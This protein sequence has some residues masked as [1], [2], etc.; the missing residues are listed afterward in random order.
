MTVGFGGVDIRHWKSSCGERSYEV[1]VEERKHCCLSF[2]FFPPTFSRPLPV[3][4]F[5][6]ENVFL[7]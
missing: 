3:N 6:I 2:N 7:V 5:S 4:T 1:T